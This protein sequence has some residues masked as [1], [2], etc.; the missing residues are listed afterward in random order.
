MQTYG[1]FI[2]ASKTRINLPIDLF[3]NGPW[4]HLATVKRSLNEYVALLHEPTQKIYLEQITATGRFNNIEEDAL[5]Q[6]L[7]NFL[8][9]KRILGFAKDKEIIVGDF[10]K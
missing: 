7:L 1:D 10:K 9:Y 4:T 3:Y 5:W 8:V 6:D 2:L